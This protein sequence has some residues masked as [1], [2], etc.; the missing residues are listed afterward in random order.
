MAY[1]LTLTNGQDLVTVADDTVDTAY[2]SLTLIGHNYPGYG[3]F[4]DENFISLLENFANGTPPNNPLQGQLWW[5]TATNNLQVRD[6]QSWKPVSGTIS[7]NNAPLTP[8]V[9]DMWWDTIAQQ[10][11]VYSGTS[12][13]WVIVGPVYTAAE[14][15][16]E[17]VGLIITDINNTQHTVLE[18]VVNGMP[19]AICSKDPVFTAISTYGTIYPGITLLPIAG[20]ATTFAGT[21]ANANL[22]NG[23]TISNFI[24]S[25]PEFSSVVNLSTQSIFTPL[26]IN[27]TSMSAFTVGTNTDFTLGANAGATQLLSQSSTTLGI[28]T[29]T[30]FLPQL[31]LT[32]AN[33][34][35]NNSF[36][37]QITNAFDLGSTTHSFRNL[38]ADNIAVSGGISFGSTLISPANIFQSSASTITINS[39]AST[40]GFIDNSGTPMLD[41]LRGLDLSVSGSAKVFIASTGA[42]T[43]T[44]NVV[45]DGSGNA[46]VAHHLTVN[47]AMTVTNGLNTADTLTV[48]QNSS[49]AA[50]TLVDDTAN[51]S[52][53]RF[54]N[55][56]MTLE[57]MALVCD[58]AGNLNVLYGGATNYLTVTPYGAVTSLRNVLDDSLGNLIAANTITASNLNNGPIRLF[59]GS[60]GDISFNDNVNPDNGVYNYTIRM[61][62]GSFQFAMATTTGQFDYGNNVATIDKSGNMIIQGMLTSNGAASGGPLA[63][64]GGTAVTLSDAG[65]LQ[66]GA[67]TSNNLVMDYQTIQARAGGV[68]ATLQLNPLGGPVTIGGS[69][70]IS[71]A[72]TVSGGITSAFL[73]TGNITGASVSAGSITATSVSASSLTGTLQTSAQPNITSVGVLTGLDVSSPVTA[74]NATIST[75]LATY[76]QLNTAIANLVN[77]G[78]VTSVVGQTGA[79]SVN[80]LEAAGLAPISN[81]TF[82]GLTTI[83]DVQ[84]TGGA[85]N[86]TPIGA[87]TPSSGTFTTMDAT[88]V[89]GTLTTAAQPNITSVGTLTS[90]NVSGTATAANAATSTELVTLGQLN[91][92]ISTVSTTAFPG[93]TDLV[94]TANVVLTANAIFFPSGF[95]YGPVSYAAPSFYKDSF[96]VV[97][98]RGS[99]T[100]NTMATGTLG[101]VYTISTLPTGYTPTYDFYIPVTN[102][103]G[104]SFTAFI[105]ADGVIS[106][107]TGGATLEQITFDCVTFQ[108]N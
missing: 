78:I 39:G 71:G 100:A 63:V 8:N 31:T 50:V 17:V 54:M 103:A 46:T 35:I 56:S 30:S 29:P 97:H 81:T 106:Y 9:G 48:I 76:G 83:P 91:S 60:Y 12:I 41:G 36:M 33:V 59:G 102:Y 40:F 80:Q 65:Y 108:T 73:S 79:V 38:Y 25:T 14:G 89:G 11:K 28:G 44:N 82:S 68:A 99:I 45:D 95:Q 1:N 19:V 101:N 90:L 57:K 93:W 87:T 18:F 23:D 86:G 84:I 88:N 98:M 6:N 7:S 77:A 4:I 94:L 10:L 61:D 37:P 32:S 27:N 26:A 75:E 58:A 51:T 53:L 52:K 15:Q 104:S 67:S 21:A 74:A 34:T 49:N 24:R 70:N 20:Q 64:N 3:Q 16:T 22:F 5:D 66:I 105:G 62:G 85:I 92:A 43:T 42:V 72:L 69:T 55:S 47:G 13:G 107:Y 2:T 96:G